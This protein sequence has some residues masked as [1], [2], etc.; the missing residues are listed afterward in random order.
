MEAARRRRK[1][2]EALRTPG[3]YQH[4]ALEAGHPIQRQWHRSKL[5]LVDWFCAPRQGERVLDVGCG[6][7]V[8]A[9]R[10]AERGA[11]VV[12]IDSN[13][14][15]IAYARRAFGRPGLDYE[16]GVLEELAFSPA[17]FDRVVCLEVIEHI[18]IDRTRTLL[19]DLRRIL[20][21]GG[22][23]TLTTPNYRGLWPL[24]EWGADRF[25]DA[26]LMGGVQHVTR[27]HRAALAGLL[28]EEGFRV[29]SIRTYCTFSPFAAALSTRFAAAVE[30]VERRIDLPFGSLLAV[31]ALNE[32]PSPA[33][34]PSAARSRRSP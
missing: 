32:A 22:R 1:L 13:Q 30:A 17:S 15:A 21:Q 8:F 18:E 33:E 34:S 2:D 27:F 20:R 31:E 9:A 4:R 19:G 7:G 23:L 6:S 16:C 14:D 29:E 5:G 10:L 12:A 24:V 25:S 3:D 28:R 26:A 11:R